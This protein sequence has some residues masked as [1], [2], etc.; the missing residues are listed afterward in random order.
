MET[1]TTRLSPFNSREAF[2]KEMRG[3][4]FCSL[5]KI[6][7]KA[8]SFLI[9]TNCIVKNL[10]KNTKGSVK[11][12]WLFQ[13]YCIH[14]CNHCRRQTVGKRGSNMYPKCPIE[15]QML[16]LPLPAQLLPIQ[17]SAGAFSFMYFIAY[18]CCLKVVFHKLVNSLSSKIPQLLQE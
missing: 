18:Q 2:K 10:Y 8:M 12:P 11:S 13:T 7:R 5:P 17:C 15:I 16:S 3:A 4:V 6:F 1:L 14:Y 9:S